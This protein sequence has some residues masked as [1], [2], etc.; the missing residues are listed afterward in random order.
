MT[1]DRR[2]ASS[3]YYEWLSAR[4]FKL[5]R[6][7]VANHRHLVQAATPV[8]RGLSDIIQRFGGTTDFEKGGK[9]TAEQLETLKAA[10]DI[11]GKVAI[12]MALIQVSQDDDE[13]L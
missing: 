10:R 6:P 7:E 12:P 11:L 2:Q 1:Y 13:I 4:D 9:F 3:G 8:E 5:P